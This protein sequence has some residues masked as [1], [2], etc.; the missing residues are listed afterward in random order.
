VIQMVDYHEKCMLYWSGGIYH[1]PTFRK[2]LI[3]AYGESHELDIQKLDWRWTALMFSILS[4]AIIGSTEATSST[5]KYASSEKVRLAKQW[6]NACI[7]CL[8]L[9][10]YASKYHIYSVQAI[11]NLHTSEHLVGSTKEWIVYQNGAIA[12]ARGLGLHRYVTCLLLRSHISDCLGL[13]H[14]PTMAN[15]TN[16]AQSVKMP[17]FSGKLVV[18]S[19]WA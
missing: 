17:W 18:G 13:D 2:E 9:G 10:D 8:Q 3:S 4:S 6:G 14:T 15:A 7:A 1:G 16:S 5:W 12:I 19:G 11:L